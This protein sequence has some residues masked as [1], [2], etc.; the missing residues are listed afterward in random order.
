MVSYYKW[1]IIICLFYFIFSFFFSWGPWEDRTFVL[2]GYLQLPLY[3]ITLVS[4]VYIIYITGIYYI[5]HWHVVN[6]LNLNLNLTRFSD[7]S[8]SHLV[9][10]QRFWLTLPQITLKICSWL[11]GSWLMAHGSLVHWLMS[12]GFMA[13]GSWLMAHGSWWPSLAYTMCTIDA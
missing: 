12:H 8:S 11:I 3:V 10:H 9:N 1:L 7:F 13:R 2:Y 6:K 5:Y 4:I